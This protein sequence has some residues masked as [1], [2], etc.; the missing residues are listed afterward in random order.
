MDPEN[1]I[2]GTYP[3]LDLAAAVFANHP[4]VGLLMAEDP[5]LVGW[6][7]NRAI[8]ETLA[9]RMGVAVPLDDFF[10]FP[11]GN[12]FWARPSALQP[13]LDLEMGWNDY[14]AEPV[15]G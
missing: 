3:M 11:L 12:M 15:C 7:E 9:A 8:A 4:N 13:L 5:H 6:D 14:P 10:D 1:L 2:G